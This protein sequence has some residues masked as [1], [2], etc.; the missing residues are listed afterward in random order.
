MPITVKSLEPSVEANALPNVRGTA[1]LTEAAAGVD[2]GKPFVALGAH[3]YQDEL[4]R[5]DQVAFLDA[6]RKLSEWEA[7]RLY[8]PTSGALAVRGKDTLGLPDTVGKDYQT[9]VD[10]IRKGLANERQQVQFDRTVEARRKDIN[11]SLSRH[12][13]NEMRKYED[14]ETESYIKTEQQ[15]GILGSDDPARVQL[16]IDRQKA[17]M[18]DFANR[19]GL[20]KGKDGGMSQYLKQRLIQIDSDTTVGVIDRYLAQGNDQMAQ[21]IFTE[22]KASNMIAGDDITKV[23]ARLKT[24]VTEGQGLRG[25]TSIWD[26]LGPKSDL[27]P[28][29]LDT[30]LRTAESEFADNIPVLKAVKQGLVER[31]NTHNA[32]QRERKEAAQDAVWRAIDGGTNLATVRKMPEYLALPGQVQNQIKEHVVDRAYMLSKRAE[33]EGND[34]LYYQRLTEASS[35]PLQD[36]FIQRNLLDDRGKLSRSQFNH[37]AEVQASLRKGDTKNA[38]KLLAS[39]RQQDRMVTEALLRMKLDPTPNEKTPKE[40]VEQIVGFRRAVREAVGAIEQQTGK[41]ATDQQVQGI[42]D[43]FVIEAVTKPGILWN[44]TKRVY[45][46]Q[47]GDNIII[48]VTDVPAAEKAKIEDALRRNGRTVTDQAVTQLYTQKLYQMRR[49]P[50]PTATGTIRR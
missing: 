21:R 3:L 44:D 47:P 22:A 43:G 12:V 49:V 35:T 16:S 26:K 13:F 5:Q 30:L 25:A 17:A 41:N 19:N 46:I 10:E 40:K 31:A 24:S 14:S 6:D 32:A 2:L 18:V 39:D 23:E 38:D 11:T 9:T 27:D 1:A 8:D 7:K 28:V 36:G 15:A 42:V 20:A 34:A 50:P 48:K 29:N 4:Y 33:G 45:Q 37:L